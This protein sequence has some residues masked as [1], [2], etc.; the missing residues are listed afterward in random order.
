MIDKSPVTPDALKQ[1]TL[2]NL[3]RKTKH[4]R[5]LSKKYDDSKT[6]QVS[7]TKDEPT[8]QNKNCPGFYFIE[9]NY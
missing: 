4:G 6:E 3:V 9:L 5:N 2:D 1:Q 8:I 7:E